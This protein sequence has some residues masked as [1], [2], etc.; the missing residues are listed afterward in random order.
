MNQNQLAELLKYSSPRVIYV[1]TW[2]NLLKKVICPFKVRVIKAVGTH[3]KGKIIWVEEVKV[4]LELKTVFIIEG[5]AY[6]Y[7]YFEIIT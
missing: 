5:K 6:Y 2:N 7:F 3:K 4:T 1:V